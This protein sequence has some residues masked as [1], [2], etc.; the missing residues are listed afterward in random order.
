M[1]HSTKLKVMDVL[2]R[3]KR[4]GTFAYYYQCPFVL[5]NS[6]THYVGPSRLY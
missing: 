6:L 5:L 4:H 2:Q 1:Q 3:G